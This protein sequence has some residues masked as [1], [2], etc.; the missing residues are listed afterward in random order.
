MS[1][2]I[3]RKFPETLIVD[4]QGIVELIAKLDRQ[5]RQQVVMA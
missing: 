4:E 5:N 1:E 2:K 3:I